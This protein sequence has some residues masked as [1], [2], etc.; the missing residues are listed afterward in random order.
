MTVADS[1]T[2]DPAQLRAHA[3]RLATIRDRFAA[4]H[5]ASASIGRNDAAYGLLCG[6]M[7]EILDARREAQAEI[8][9]YLEENLSLA[10]ESL[11]RTAQDYADS[12]AAAADRVRRAR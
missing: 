7:S 6:W 1:F 9:A 4:V 11:I 3:A 10:E 2:V 8:H 12:D 5:A